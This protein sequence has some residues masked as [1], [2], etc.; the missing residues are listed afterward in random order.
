MKRKT[1]QVGKG[2]DSTKKSTEGAST[3]PNKLF[4][5]VWLKKVSIG[6]KRT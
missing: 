2:G 4:Q 3:F 5:R 6:T 1:R